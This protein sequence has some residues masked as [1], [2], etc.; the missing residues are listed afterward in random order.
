MEELYN[1]G[2]SENTI[3]DMIMIN[4]ELS[5]LSK[6]E[7]IEKENIL[8]SINCDETQIMN[9]ISSNSIFLSRTNSE[10]TKLLNY[11]INLGFTTL[12]ILIDSNPDILNL[13]IFEIE[14]YIKKRIDADENLETIID[15]LDSKPYLFNEL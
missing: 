13:D 2:I 3:N 15:E 8:R 4:N 14:K 5:S 6:E 10:V 7:I 12:N 1:L 9:I 11:L